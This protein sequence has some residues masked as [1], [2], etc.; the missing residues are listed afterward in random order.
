ME[1][2]AVVRQ[3][4]DAFNRADLDAIRDAFAVEGTYAD[5]ITGGPIKRDAVKVQFTGF[6]AGFPDAQF[7]TVG[8]DPISEHMWVWRWV[9]HGTNSGSY[10]G[11][12]S[13]GRSVA[14]PGCEFI[15]VR[16]DKIHQVV[17][18][19]DRLTMLG[20]MGLAPGAP[21]QPETTVAS[22]KSDA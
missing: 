20:Q 3:Y 17:G 12:P 6:Y 22:V 16:G 9:L 19:F 11:L 13:T 14:L 10:R 2:P 5:P 8:L 1:T 18:Y 4:V 7:E 15:E 21:K